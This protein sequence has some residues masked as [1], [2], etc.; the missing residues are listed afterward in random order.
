[1]LSNIDVNENDSNMLK[2]LDLNEKSIVMDK[3]KN[4][5]S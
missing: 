2:N 4:K 5:R 3:L 1:M